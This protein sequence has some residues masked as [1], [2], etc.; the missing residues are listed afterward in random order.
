MDALAHTSPHASTW[1]HIEV[2]AIPWA[3]AKIAALAIATVLAFGFRVTALSTYGLSEDEL[4]KVHAI[5]QY[6]AGD[7]GANAEHPMLMKLA[8]WGSVDLARAWNRVAPAD[9]SVPLET[10]LRL[11][12]AIAGTATTGAL[13]GVADLLFGG[14]AAAAAALIWACD[15]NAIGI[16]RMGKEDSFLLLF[17]L[18]AVLCYE[19]AKRSGSTGSADTQRWYALSGASFGLML[20]SKY[21]P[22]YLGIYALFNTVTDPHPGRNKP[23]KLLYYGSMLAVFAI[24]DFAILMPGTWQYAARYVQGAMLAHHGFLYAGQL[25]VTN[26]PISPLG[27]PATY[28]LHLLGT[29]VPIALLAAAVPG[30]IELVRRRRERGFVLLRVL[31]VF[32]LVP[33]SLM[34]A[35]F[36]RYSLPMLATLDL[37]AAVGLVAGTRWLLRKQWLTRLTRVSVSALAL[38]VFAA[39]LIVS[40]RSAAPFYSVFENEIGARVEAPGAAFPEETYDYGVREAVAEIAALAAPSAVI[41]SDAPSVV[42]HY[43]ERSGRPDIQSRS[44]SGDGLPVGRRDAWV[45]VQDEHATF[46]NHALVQQL[47]ARHLPIMQFTARNVLAV[48]VFRVA[49]K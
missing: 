21:M 29:K 6:R 19:R 20:A 34:A 13:F 10:A 24:A 41:V 38:V 11:P 36:V 12:N 4:N 2:G 44:L 16:N 49:G 22:H 40:V 15:V 26:V 8:M 33:Y 46:E 37:T 42:V 39:A 48:Q 45:I 27:V 47:R 3:H 5:D 9:R 18:L 32:L 17:F 35:K 7:F 14:A 30:A 1:R 31:I 23:R 28:Y 43:L 25:Y